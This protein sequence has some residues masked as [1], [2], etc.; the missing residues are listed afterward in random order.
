MSDIHSGESPPPE[1]QSAKQLHDVP[2]SGTGTDDATNKE[3][4]NKSALDNLT[5]NPKG[6]LDDEVTRKFA[7]TTKM[8]PSS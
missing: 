8:A 1:T 5:S 6:P 4:T 3:Q 2:A 7:K